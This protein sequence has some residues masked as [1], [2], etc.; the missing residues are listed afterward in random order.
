[1]ESASFMTVDPTAGIA[2]LSR[3]MA[4]LVT[5]A[6]WAVTPGLALYVL[7][8]PEQ[9]PYHGWVA[10]AGFQPRPLPPLVAGAVFAALGVVSV[11]GLW[12]LWE[13][14][15]LFEAY[16]T[17]AIFTV[18]A[19]RRLRHCGYALMVAGAGSPLGSMLLSAAL[20]LDLPRHGRSLVISM[21]SDDLLLLLIGGVLLVIARVMGE[22]ARIAEENAGFI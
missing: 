22:A 3:R 21:S 18:A 5:A 20:S 16:A 19:A 7:L 12:G 17:G 2:R 4:W 6:F 13:L 8:F 9:L 1:V 14:K 11:P 10:M 15:R